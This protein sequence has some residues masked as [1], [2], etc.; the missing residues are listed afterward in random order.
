MLMGDAHGTNGLGSRALY[1]LNY[2]RLEVW[3]VARMNITNTELGMRT[4]RKGLKSLRVACCIL[5]ALTSPVVFAQQK[6]TQ[7]RQA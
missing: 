5:A 6:E 4:L 3:R 1:V 2:H 7:G